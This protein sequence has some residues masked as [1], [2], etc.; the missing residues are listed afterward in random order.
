VTAWNGALAALS[1]DDKARWA[2]HQKREVP[3]DLVERLFA[4]AK[5]LSAKAEPTRALAGKIEQ[6]VAAACPWLVGGS[7]DLDSST[8][9]A[10]EGSASISPKD[11]KSFAGR[12]VHYGVREH[13]MLSI[14]NGI[15]VHGDGGGFVPFG[16]TFLIFSE[17]CRPAIRLASLMEQQSI[18]VFTHDSIFLGEDGPTHQPI[19]QLEALRAIPGLRVVRPADAFE[20]AS[21]WAYAIGRKHAPTALVLSRQKV[22]PLPHAADPKHETLV[23]GA[24][25]L[26]DPANAKVVL[27]GTGAEVALAVAAAALLEKDGIAARVVSAPCI[28]ALEDLGDAAFDKVLPED[29]LPRVTIEAGRTTGWKRFTGRKGLAIGIDRFGASAPEADLAKLFGLTPD[30]IAAKV[31]ALLGAG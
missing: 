29:G 6:V 11:P 28:E 31:K 12:N 14:N 5:E 26:L 18:Y 15:A 17:Y 2:A 22:A 25:R 19:E 30:A 1:A 8:H 16:A 21:A 20:C 13:G 4:K 7:A 24:Y 10:I 9:T 27:I 23:A 3:A